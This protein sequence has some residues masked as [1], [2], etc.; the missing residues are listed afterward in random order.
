MTGDSNTPLGGG[1]QDLVST[2]KSGVN[3]LGQLLV[4]IQSAFPRIAGTF[5]MAVAATNTVTDARIN[6][7]AV[8][9]LQATNLSAGTLQ[10]S[11]KNLVVS[12]VASGSFTVSTANATNA[13]GTETFS[14]VAFNPV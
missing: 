1:L 5:T 8:V 13:A 10:G 3:Y 2:Q 7:N 12:A 6:A 11:A 4:A 14:Y 9:W